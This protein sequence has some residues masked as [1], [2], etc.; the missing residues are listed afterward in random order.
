MLSKKKKL[1]PDEHLLVR[2]ALIVIPVTYSLPNILYH[3]LK[4]IKY[5]KSKI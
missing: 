5:E 1:N 2:N 3:L 4:Y